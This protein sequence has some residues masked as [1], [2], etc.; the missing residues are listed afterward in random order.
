[1]HE[2]DLNAVLAVSVWC[3]TASFAV[4]GSVGVIC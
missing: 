1:M 3:G 2:Y 4:R